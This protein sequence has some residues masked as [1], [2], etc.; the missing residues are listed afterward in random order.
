[1]ALKRVDLYVDSDNLDKLKKMCE[2]EQIKQSEFINK[3][4]ASYL[5]LLTS[6]SGGGEFVELVPS[7]LLGEK[8]TPE[9]KEDV[10]KLLNETCYQFTKITQGK[11]NINLDLLKNHLVNAFNLDEE[12]KQ[13][14]LNNYLKYLEIL[15]G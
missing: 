6:E 4:I 2:L 5:E 11:E 8:L 3:A 15:E 7:C 12:N 1:M 10:I 9:Q 13:D 14:L